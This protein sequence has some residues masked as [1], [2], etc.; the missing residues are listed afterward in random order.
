MTRINPIDPIYRSNHQKHGKGERESPWFQF[1][2]DE[3]YKAWCRL[4]RSAYSGKSF[5]VVYAHYR[6][7]NNAGIALKP[8]YSGLPL[9]RQ[10]HDLQ[11]RIGQYNFRHKQWWEDNVK[12][13][14]ERWA[15]E[16]KKH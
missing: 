16:N 13:H 11:H 15:N 3:D 8:P 1:G 10:E 9:T 2:T 5:E 14:L 6:T 4:Q 12:S 7:A